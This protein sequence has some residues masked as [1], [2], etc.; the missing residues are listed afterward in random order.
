MCRVSI[1]A[2]QNLIEPMLR[3]FAI[4]GGNL[5][6]D[7]SQ[8]RGADENEKGGNAFASCAKV[9]EA[10][11]NE[12]ETGEGSEGHSMSITASQIGEFVAEQSRLPL[13]RRRRSGET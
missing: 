13:A 9:L 1:L 11:A 5:D 8:S 2:G 4:D 12:V 10:M 3:V 6:P 7:C